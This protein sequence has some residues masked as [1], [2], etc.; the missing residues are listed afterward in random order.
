MCCLRCC[1]VVCH[2]YCL[3]TFLLSTSVH[4]HVLEPK[5]HVILLTQCMY[6]DMYVVFCILSS[7]V[8]YIHTLGGAIG[9]IFSLANAVAVALY[10]VG[11]AETVSALLMV[12]MYI[13][14]MYIL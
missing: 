9:I 10:I 7:C 5:Q 12:S 13:I 2:L 8:F 11:F 14:Y 6:L 4:V 3:I 1:C